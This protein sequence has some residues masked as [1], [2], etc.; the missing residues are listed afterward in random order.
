MKTISYVLI[1]IL[2]LLEAVAESFLTKGSKEINNKKILIWV[3]LGSFLY[4]LV[5][6]LFYVALR[7]QGDLTV[8]N[9]VWQ[10][11]NIIIISIFGYFFFKEKL[12]KLQMFGI[13]LTIIGIVL[14]DIKPKMKVK[15]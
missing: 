9:T 4:I 6:I 15:S 1:L 7:I 2:I 12:S 13:I 14:V 8:L 3:F 5:A 10:G 11:A